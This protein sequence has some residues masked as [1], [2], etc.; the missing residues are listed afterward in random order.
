MRENVHNMTIFERQGLNMAQKLL[1]HEYLLSPILWSGFE[2]FRIHVWKYHLL[3]TLPQFDLALTFVIFSPHTKS[4]DKFSSTQKCVNYNQWDFAT[5]CVNF[6]KTDFS[7]KQHKFCIYGDIFYIIH[8]SD[9]EKFRFFHI[10]HGKTSEISPH[11]E[12]FLISLQSS[13]MES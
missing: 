4:L 7:R 2:N 10:C 9:V 1:K 6:D 3:R 8:M 13:Y 5:K 11:V 12:K